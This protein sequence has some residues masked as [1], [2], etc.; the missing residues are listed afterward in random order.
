MQV[1]R[2]HKCLLYAEF[3]SAK[4]I[5]MVHTALLGWLFSQ[6][7]KSRCYSI[8]RACGLKR[9]GGFPKKKAGRINP[10]SSNHSKTITSK[11]KYFQVKINSYLLTN[12]ISKS[13]VNISIT[14]C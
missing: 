5:W 14:L 2:L 13:K 11:M 3:I 7:V 8:C 10:A 4:F 6:G 9:S 1:L 12:F